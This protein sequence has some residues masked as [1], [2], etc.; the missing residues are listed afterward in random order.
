M[1]RCTLCGVVGAT[2]GCREDRCKCNYH[3][4]CARAASVTF[5][6]SQYMLACKKHAKR[7]R[8]EEEE[9]PCVSV[10]QTSLSCG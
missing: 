10:R 7:F 5:Y 9:E 4:P 3:L 2:I 1:R 8:T 6:P